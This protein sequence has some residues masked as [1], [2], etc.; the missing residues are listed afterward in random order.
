MKHIVLFFLAVFLLDAR[1]DMRIWT[2]IKGDTVEAEFIGIFADKVVLRRADGVEIKV[3]QNGL[4]ASDIKY[5][6]EA[7]P[8]EMTLEVSVKNDKKQMGS[9]SSDYSSYGWERKGQIVKCTATVA[10]KSKQENKTPLKARL[11]VFSKDLTTDEVEVVALAEQEFSFASQN[12]VEF[13]STPVSLEYSKSSYDGNRGQE[14]EGYLLVV[15]DA[16]GKIMAMKASRKLY[17]ENAGKIRPSVK[18]TRFDSDMDML[19]PPGQAPERGNRR[20]RN[21]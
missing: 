12:M 11:Y 9:Y 16:E 19:N 15:E 20:N 3:P 1:A 7:I 2:S 18:G 4:S 17:E 8:P 13:T 6:S 5:L 10:K 21:N 14:Y